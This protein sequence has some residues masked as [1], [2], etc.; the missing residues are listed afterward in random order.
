MLVLRGVGGREG[1]ERE[2]DGWCVLDWLTVMCT[3]VAGGGS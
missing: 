1:G 3:C 2:R